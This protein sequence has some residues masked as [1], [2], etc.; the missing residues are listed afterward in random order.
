VLR[1]C[2]EFRA[3]NFG[4]LVT[5]IHEAQ[6]IHPAHPRHLAAELAHPAAP[7]QQA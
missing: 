3:S 1:I 5:K 6:H 2:F 7:K 4:F